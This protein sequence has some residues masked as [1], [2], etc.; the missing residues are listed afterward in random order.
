[1]KELM[2]GGTTGDAAGLAVNLSDEQLAVVY[3]TVFTP[4]VER[5]VKRDVLAVYIQTLSAIR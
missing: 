3:Q 1:V 2:H 5:K 4:L